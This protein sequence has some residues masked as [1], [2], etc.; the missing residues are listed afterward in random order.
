VVDDPGESKNLRHAN[1]AV[2]DELQ[3]LAE[4]WLKRVREP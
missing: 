2:A 1:P 4:Q 3:T